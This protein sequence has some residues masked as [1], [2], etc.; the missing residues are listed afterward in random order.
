MNTTI[1]C[2]NDRSSFCY[3]CV[4]YI[5]ST[6][7]KPLNQAAKLKYEEIF[8]L[9][10][11]NME[12]NWVPTSICNT[13]RNNLYHLKRHKFKFNTPAVWR[14]PKDHLTDCL[15]CVFDPK[16]KFLNKIN[17][18]NRSFLDYSSVS[19]VSLPCNKPLKNVYFEP[20]SDEE[21]VIME[22]DHEGLNVEF[23]ES[24]EH[25]WE[26]VELNNLVRSLDLSIR[27]ANLLGTALQRKK[28]LSK[29]CNSSLKNCFFLLKILT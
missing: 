27:K 24:S 11:G 13:C 25:T 10:I 14:E 6:A 1:K 19:S 16:L 9:K 18:N 20:D 17:K 22:S 3:I 8:D 26:Q 23:Q 21:D 15:F 29:T 4:R 5:V 7:R 28:S 12:K 2:K